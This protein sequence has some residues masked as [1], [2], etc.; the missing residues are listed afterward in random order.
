MLMNLLAQ[1]QT[2]N[3]YNNAAYMGMQARQAHL[4]LIR[5]IKIN[6][7]GPDTDVFSKTNFGSM[8]QLAARD[9]QLQMTEIKS[10]FTMTAMDAWQKSL[11]EQAKNRKD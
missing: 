7:G 8:A 10:N 2:I 4:G 11:K 6:P 5:G 1:L 9:K 3:Q